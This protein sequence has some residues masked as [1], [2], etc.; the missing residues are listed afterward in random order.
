MYVGGL[1]FFWVFRSSIDYALRYLIRGLG[2][3]CWE[4]KVA[5]MSRTVLIF[6][7]SLAVAGRGDS[8]AP[9]LSSFIDGVTLELEDPGDG[10]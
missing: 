5:W 7:D 2:Y 3:G 10:L 8:S 1:F 9:P 6:C 4:A